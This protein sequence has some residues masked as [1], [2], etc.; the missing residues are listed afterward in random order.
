MRRIFKRNVKGS[1]LA[2]FKVEYS[3]RC[4]LVMQFLGGISNN[5]PLDCHA[6]NKLLRIVK[7]ILS[8]V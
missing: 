8:G 2:N 6:L 5:V 4:C 7:K 1:G 3:R